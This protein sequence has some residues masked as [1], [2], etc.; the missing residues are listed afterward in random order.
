MEIPAEESAAS[1]M[2][3]AVF[4]IGDDRAAAL[5]HAVDFADLNGKA[6][7][8]QHIAEDAAGEQRTLSADAD[9]HD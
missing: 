9:D 6:L 8:K 3:I 7:L 4:D 5:A 2:G 1:V